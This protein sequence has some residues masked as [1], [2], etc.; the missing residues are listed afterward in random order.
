MNF[1]RR[2]IMKRTA[3]AT[4][5]ALLGSSLLPAAVGAAGKTSTTAGGPKR[6]VFF[7]ASN[8]MEPK[9]LRPDELD[10][11]HRD[12]RSAT[13]HI[14]VALNDYTL[15]RWMEPL[16]DVREHLSV[17]AGL[18]GYHIW[19]EHG[20]KFGFLAGTKKADVPRFKTIDYALAETMPKTP[21][22][23]IGF[24][25]SQL[26]LMKKTPVTTA[27]SAAGDGKA[28][29][30]FADPRLAFQSLFGC[31]A[32]GT[33]AEGFATETEW[34]EQTIDQAALIRR[35]FAGSEAQRFDL[36]VE[37]LRRARQQRIDLLA[38]KDR[39]AANLPKLG[40]EL[41]NPETDRQWH[42]VQVE[43]GIAALKAGITNVVT[44]DNGGGGPD[45][46]PLS[47]FDFDM[48]RVQNSHYLG[49]MNQV[50]DPEW[51]T[52]RHWSLG[53]VRRIVG[54]LQKT[55]EPGGTGTM[56]DHTLI[57]YCSDCGEN[58]HAVGYEWPFLLIGNLGGRIR[59]G[60][61]LQYPVQGRGGFASS[62]QR[63]RP[64]GGRSVNA[65]WAT[66]LHAAGHPVDHFN[67]AG[68]EHIDRKGPLEELLV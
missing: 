58:Q 35:R 19:P 53:L 45:W 14:E 7:N 60:R 65:L 16:A 64:E 41:Q 6:F 27:A 30:E 1:T 56:F 44:F 11:A 63:S 34:Y 43:I 40:N 10:E 23:M 26:D 4:G 59:T 13:K 37:G 22:N 55:P 38:M 8:G 42:E 18:F 51:M 29:P 52:F 66:L 47:G 61:Y 39:L 62:P 5:G 33:S 9:H 36:Y 50:K 31:A 24:A 2:E 48:G 49:H 28:V 20:A 54:E 68:Q 12:A 3:L 57:V 67:L 25:M 32:G 46:S 21:M 17:V 15:P